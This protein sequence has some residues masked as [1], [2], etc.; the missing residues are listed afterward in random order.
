MA[1][2]VGPAR[3]KPDSENAPRA[4]C[5]DEDLVAADS[6]GASKL[7]SCNNRPDIRQHHLY[8]PTCQN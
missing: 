5:A 7:M 3:G 4:R 2:Q 6:I 1:K 8:I